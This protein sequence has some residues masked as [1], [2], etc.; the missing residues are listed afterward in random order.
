MRRGAQ[1]LQPFYGPP[2]GFSFIPEIQPILDR[3]CIIYH[4]DRSRPR[5]S[6]PA[7]LTPQRLAT[8]ALWSLTAEISPAILTELG[9]V[10]ALE[11]LAEPFPQSHGL[12]VAAELDPA[13]SPDDEALRD[14]LFHATRELLFNAAKHSGT[15][16]ASLAARVDDD[17]YLV[18]EVSDGGRGFELATAEGHE[19]LGLVSIRERAKLLEGS[20]DLQ[21][22]PGAGTVTRLRMPPTVT[23]PGAG[24]GSG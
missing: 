17:G 1:P 23:P 18:V 13:V 16:H 6:I 2:R 24:S 14:F 5:T 9:L 20:L 12:D 21:A 15:D 7:H 4:S 11:W 10:P 3:H 8:A 22:R 19:G